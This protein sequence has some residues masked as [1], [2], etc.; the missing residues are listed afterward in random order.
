MNK[1]KFRIVD[2]THINLVYEKALQVKSA[3]EEMSVTK[4]ANII[5]LPMSAIPSDV[6]YDLTSCYIA[7]F[8]KSLL[9]ETL[10]AG[11]PKPN[12]TLH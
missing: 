8:D 9:E 3:L 7:L 6:L 11:Y 4:Q 10:I 2:N 5:N 12:K 1:R